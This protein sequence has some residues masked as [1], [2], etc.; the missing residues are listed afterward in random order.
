MGVDHRRRHILVAQQ[1]LHRTDVVATFQQMGSERMS[2]SVR[3]DQLGNAG[4][5]RR[6]FHRPLYPLLVDMMTAHRTRTRVRRKPL[7]RKNV[8]PGQ[9]PGSVGI[10]HR[11]RIR[12][13]HLATPHSQISRMLRLHKFHLLSQPVVQALRQHRHPVL[14]ALALAHHNLAPREFHILDTQTQTFQQAHSTA[15]QQTHHHIHQRIVHR[16]HQPPHLV[17]RQ[18]RGQATRTLGP[19]D[20]RQPGEIQSQHFLVQKQQCRQ[21]LRLRRS[22]H[23]AF[24]RQ[25]SQERFQLGLA[26]FRRVALAVKDDVSFCP[27]H[28]A[29]LGADAVMLEADTLAQ[30]VQ[31]FR[32]RC[33]RFEFYG[34][35]RHGGCVIGHGNHLDQGLGA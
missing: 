30:L 33:L 10:F 21:S 8:L 25:R 31:Q 17:H 13:P 7:R 22:T 16:L 34:F 6:P 4:A 1:F 5:G 3:A 14:V 19:G 27:L 23:V 24:H 12:Q 35:I 15:I 32:R 9:R 2:Q 20:L 18:H 26:H 29:L 28:V 11:E